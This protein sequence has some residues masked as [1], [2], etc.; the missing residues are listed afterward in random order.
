MI[1]IFTNELLLDF[2]CNKIVVLIIIKF[3]NVN[4]FFI[5]TSFFNFFLGQYYFTSLAIVLAVR[6]CYY[7]FLLIFYFIK[8]NNLFV[9]R[10]CDLRKFNRIWVFQKFI[11]CGKF[12]FT[13]ELINFLLKKKLGKICKKK[14]NLRNL[15]LD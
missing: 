4:I 11:F 3:F 9:I 5:I 14:I 6:Y 2:M 8:K 10:R 13:F 1:N 15:F 7:F 12:K